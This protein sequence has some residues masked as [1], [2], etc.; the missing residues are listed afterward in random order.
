MTHVAKRLGSHQAVDDVSFDVANGEAVAIL[1]PSGSGKTTLLRLIAGLDT[2]DRGEISIDGVRVAADGRSIVPPY[3]RRI[4]FVFQDLALWPHMTVQQQLEF[5]LGSLKVARSVWRA[6]IN[7]AL[8]LVRIEHLASRYPH[9]LSGGE[10]QRA[11]LARTLA[12]QPR[13]ILLDE[14]LASL[15]SDLRAH[16][17]QELASLQRSLAVTSVYVTHDRDDAAVIADRVLS[18]RAGTLVTI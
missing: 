9:Q 5:V 12:G 4:G 2:P 14:P 8:T 17:R 7:D 15:D 3:E 10:Q 16:L 18:M 6:R 1:G 13:L 11:A